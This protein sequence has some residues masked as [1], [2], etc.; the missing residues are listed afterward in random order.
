MTRIASQ[1][2]EIASLPSTSKAAA[3]TS[4]L[5]TILDGTGSE[6]DEHE[7]QRQQQLIAFVEHVTASDSSISLVVS[8]HVVAAFVSRLA[9]SAS[10]SP[11]DAQ[12]KQAIAE[13]TLE[14]CSQRQASFEDQVRPC[15][16]CLG[17]HR[18]FC[19]ADAACARPQ[20]VTLRELLADIL[21]KNEEWTDAAK[22]L[23][24]IP[25]ESSN[26]CVCARGLAARWSSSAGSAGALRDSRA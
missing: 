22:M 18:A 8:K 1:L 9:A 17:T 7:Q 10:A 2:D 25:L 16:P 19:W 23:Q 13:K 26:R 15:L 24:G 5:D 6:G 21:E 20:I 14:N 12:F 4:L 11:L 3:Y